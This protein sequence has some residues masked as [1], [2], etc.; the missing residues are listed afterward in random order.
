MDLSIAQAGIH[1]QRQNFLAE[2]FGV[3]EVT[4]FI[5]QILISRLEMAGYRIVDAGL[6][7]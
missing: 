4:G 3:G 7:S 2:S 1:G 6:N 5:S